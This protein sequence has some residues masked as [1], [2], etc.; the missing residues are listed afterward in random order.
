MDMTGTA[1]IE[2]LHGGQCAIAFF[3]VLRKQLNCRHQSCGTQARVLLD[4]RQPAIAAQRLLQAVRRTRANQSGKP[5][6]F[7]Q[8]RGTRCGFFG[9]TETTFEESLERIM[10]CPA[11]FTLLFGSTICTNPT[12]HIERGP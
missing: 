4:L 8:E 11:R 10:Q 12:R 1:C 6:V 9:L 3:V 7:R 5:G 2:L